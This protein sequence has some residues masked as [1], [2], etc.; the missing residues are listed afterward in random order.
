MNGILAALTAGLPVKINTVVMNGQNE[1]EINDFIQ[2]GLENSVEE[3]RF[4]E[5]MPLCGTK[6]NPH[7]VF[8]F[9][10]TIRNVL[11]TYSNAVAIEEKGGVAEV[12]RITKGKK[13]VRV[14]FIRTL[15]KPFCGECSRVRIS[16]DGIL[17]P[18]LFSHDGHNLKPYL[19]ANQHEELIAAIHNT[20]WRKQ[21]GNEF[22]TAYENRIPLEQYIFSENPQRSHN[23]SIRAIG[24]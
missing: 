5:F 2:F 13:T 1:H 18:C 11:Q 16:A 20:I 21:S 10:E 6:W 22:A 19:V 4:I 3:V 23:P 24:G 14:G 9:T 17:R 7:S 15:S 8:P 12:Y